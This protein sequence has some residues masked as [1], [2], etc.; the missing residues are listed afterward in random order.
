MMS[1]KRV[2]DSASEELSRAME[3]LGDPRA[4]ELGPGAREQVPGESD[5]WVTQPP[6]AEV[7][8]LDRERFDF[9]KGPAEVAVL[10]YLP[11]SPW[12]GVVLQVIPEALNFVSSAAIE[13][14]VYAA[15]RRCDDPQPIRGRDPL[16]TIRVDA[17]TPA[18]T[19]YLRGLP[20]GQVGSGIALTV[21]GSPN[22][23]APGC[24]A[25]LSAS[26]V[27]RA[28]SPTLPVSHATLSAYD[29]A[30]STRR[31]LRFYTTGYE[32]AIGTANNYGF[33][34]PSSA[35]QL[36]GVQLWTSGAAGSTS[37]CLH[38][39]GD[40]TVASEREVIQTLSAASSVWFDFRA[41]STRFSAGQ[42]VSVSVDPTSAPGD[43]TVTCVWELYP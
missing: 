23:V 22:M 24:A 20:P 37:V 7:I 28:A 19:L 35:G 11:C 32:T 33:W 26:L 14:L 10:P 27:L 4:P 5:D 36:V 2:R 21:R 42:R 3:Q 18:D 41:K 39:D 29:D 1:K 30:G 40:T 34:V 15:A 6:A 25:T 43:V 38:L 9:E 12:P 31:Y 8:V 13:V 17:S 16:A